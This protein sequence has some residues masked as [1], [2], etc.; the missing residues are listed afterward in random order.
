MISL[1]FQI[2]NPFKHKPFK[3]YWGRVWSVSKHKDFEIQF[4]KYAW[5]LFEFNLNLKWFGSDH[6]GPA[7]EINLFGWTLNVA[8]HD[9]RHWD[10]DA[11]DWE[12]YPDEG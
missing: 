12:I 5:N 1:Y 10:H 2:Q 11:D 7:I 9:K 4:M 3:S 6:A 8:L